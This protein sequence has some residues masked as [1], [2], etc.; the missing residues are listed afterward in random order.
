MRVARTNRPAR[1]GGVYIAV[2]GTSLLVALLGLSALV[3]QRI[4]N[5]VVTAS[6]DIRQAQ[7][8]AN[9]AVELATLIMKQEANWRTSRPHGDWFTNRGTG[10]GTCSV[11]VTDPIDSNLADDPYEPVV[12]LGTGYR[13]QAQQRMKVTIDSRKQPISS[14]RSTVA[15][16]D[17]ITLSSDTLRTN[18]LITANEISAASSQVYGSVEAVTISGSTYNGTTTQVSSGGR[19]TMPDWASV[20]DYYRTNGTELNYGSLPLSPTSNFVSNWTIDNGTTNWTGT[21]PGIATAEVTTTNNWSKTPNFSLRVRNRTHWS[22]GAAQRIDHF[23]KPGQQYNVSAWV[24]A[25]GLVGIRTFRLTMYTKGTGNSNASSASG[26]SATAIVL[27]GTNLPSPHLSGTVT[28]PSWSGD[29]EYAFIKISDSGDSP[30][31]QSTSEFYL[32][33]VEVTEDS[34]GRYIYRKVLSPTVNQL[35]A[36]APTDPEGLYWINCNGNRL[37]IERSRILGT[38]LV[39]NPGANSRVAHGPIH[40]SPAVPGYPALLVDADSASNA[41]FAILAI[42][43]GLSEK[44]QGVNFNP[45]GA[46]HAQFGEEADLNDIYPSEICGLVAVEDDLTFQNRPFIRGQVLVGD[47]LANSSGTLD[48]EYLPESLLSPPPG[49]VAP[50]AN[51]RRPASTYKAV[52]P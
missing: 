10:A 7:M 12:V 32:D 39:V 11:N 26:P 14:L 30:F 1:L 15:A 18:G 49:F 34:S 46:P 31:G 48:V 2:L 42:N 29:L 45:A 6:T 8:N 20:F 47:D 33:D 23:V 19:P 43:R 27:G 44:E 9:T 28:A 5:R 51:Q 37:N 52:L 17:L 40:W 16:G 41:D 13:G 38:L 36:G 50:D 25:P 35:Y 22:A 4:Q 21:P 24:H 3:G